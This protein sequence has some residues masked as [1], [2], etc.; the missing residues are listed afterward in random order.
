MNRFLFT[1][2]C[3][4]MFDPL[5]NLTIVCKLA[6][7]D[8]LLMMAAELLFGSAVFE[9]LMISSGVLYGCLSMTKNSSIKGLIKDNL[10][11]IKAY[12]YEA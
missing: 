1:L 6:G 3:N 11:F 4:D 12:T 10:N 9:S 8:A 7:V 5:E 2:C